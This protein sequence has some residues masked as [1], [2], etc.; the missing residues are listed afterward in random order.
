MNFYTLN[1][2]FTHFG[3]GV[4]NRRARVAPGGALLGPVNDHS[5][6]GAKRS[7]GNEEDGGRLQ[8][9]MIAALGT[10]SAR[11]TFAPQGAEFY[12]DGGAPILASPGSICFTQCSSEMINRR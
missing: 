12:K 9:G 7:G 6:C 1:C 2:I 5:A 3:A 11:D 10:P 4:K 8:R